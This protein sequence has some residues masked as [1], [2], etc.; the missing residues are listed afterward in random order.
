[1]YILYLSDIKCGMQPCGREGSLVMLFSS[2]ISGLILSVLCQLVSQRAV[3]KLPA[4]LIKT[5]FPALT[6]TGCNTACSWTHEGTPWLPRYLGLTLLETSRVEP[7]QLTLSSDSTRPWPL[8]GH[9]PRGGGL[10]RDGDQGLG[11]GPAGQER[12]LVLTHH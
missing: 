9:A 11:K 7:A 5:V 8:Q 12:A 6:G 10:Q 2:F 4:T 3:L 1:M